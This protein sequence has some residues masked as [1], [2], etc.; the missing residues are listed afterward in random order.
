MDLS[1]LRGDRRAAGAVARDVNWFGAE[2]NPCMHRMT[3]RETS[4]F[5]IPPL[6]RGASIFRPLG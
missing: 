5:T 4:D 6:I 2:E 1:P 3:C